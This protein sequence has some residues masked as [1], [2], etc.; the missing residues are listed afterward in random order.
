MR[1]MRSKE[2]KYILNPGDGCD[3]E[4]YDGVPVYD[5]RKGDLYRISSGGIFEKFD[6]STGNW[7]EVEDISHV[8]IKVLR[9][10]GLHP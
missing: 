6:R 4:L 1:P 2:V 9:A 7:Y 3:V 5:A 10:A 8:Q